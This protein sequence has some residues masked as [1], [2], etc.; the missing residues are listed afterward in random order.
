MI[1][2]TIII[3]FYN[4]EKTIGRA[5]DSLRRMAPESREL[6]EVLAIDDGSQDRGAEIVEAGKNDLAP[7]RVELIRQQNTGTAGAR[8][9]GL[10]QG[11]GDWIF[12]LDAD[13][14]LTF[15][16]VA[17]IKK[18]P[19]HSALAFPVQWFRDD[20]P[21]GFVRPPFATP[22]TYLDIL[23]A[24]NP[25]SICNFII[26][27]DRIEAM[28]D[29]E[30]VY[31]EDWIFWFENPLIFERMKIFGRQT[32]AHIHAHGA[33]KSSNYTKAGSYRQRVA[34]EI[35]KRFDERL[36]LKQKNNLLMQKQIGAIL[37]GK[38]IMFGNLFRFPCNGRL[39]G[40]LLIYVI[41]R[42]NFPRFD[43]YGRS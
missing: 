34:D 11:R 13:D 1:L 38:K 9:T 29:R 39:Y 14:E 12:F 15:D 4:A 8:N 27:K 19:G 40:K 37:Q 3:P 32:S 23:T 31:L 18:W 43:I 21:R 35:L 28:F 16:P 2:L 22:E 5:L 41:L 42:S 7:L 33:N 30:F 17:F 10:R 20:R 36:T 26:R 6:V 25:F 24:A